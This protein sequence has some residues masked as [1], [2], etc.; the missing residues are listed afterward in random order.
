[1]HYQAYLLES[2]VQWKNDRAVAAVEDILEYQGH[3]LI[4]VPFIKKLS[5]WA[6][7]RMGMI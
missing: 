7:Y 1:M 4:V 5:G 2:I 6:T 3:T